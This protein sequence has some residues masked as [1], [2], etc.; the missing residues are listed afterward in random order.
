[1][2][3]DKQAAT[4]TM[5]EHAEMWWEEKGNQVPS[6][7]TPE[8]V[9]MYESWVEFAFSYVCKHKKSGNLVKTI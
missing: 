2:I 9:Q 6:K 7:G 1:M 8:W 5:A 4:M 3:S